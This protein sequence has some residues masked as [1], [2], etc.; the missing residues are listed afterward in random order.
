LSVVFSI[1]MWLKIEI[2][3]LKV[4][5]K[6]YKMNKLWMN[7]F[8]SSFNRTFIYFALPWA[9]TACVAFAISSGSPR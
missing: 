6:L 4:K 7:V 9:A 5:A 2:L 3:V 8:H 1:K